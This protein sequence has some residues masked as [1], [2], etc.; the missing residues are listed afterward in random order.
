MDVLQHISLSYSGP[1]PLF[2]RNLPLVSLV[3]YTV[4]V[5]NL[6]GVLLRQPSTTLCRTFFGAKERVCR[7]LLLAK[8][9]SYSR[10]KSL[11]GLFRALRLAQIDVEG[12]SWLIYPSNTRF[13]QAEGRLYGLWSLS[14]SRAIYQIRGSFR[15]H[16][17]RLT[18]NT[19]VLCPVIF[20]L[21]QQFCMLH[22][23][24]ALTT[25]EDVSASSAFAFTDQV[26]CKS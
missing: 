15:V 20:F 11:G 9:R 19:Y 4:S 8:S 25:Y 24:T 23:A 3:L 18:I 7:L 5:D 14:R 1:F 6:F 17:C 10:L 22:Y 26:G 16:Y 2:M 12:E 13:A 21:L